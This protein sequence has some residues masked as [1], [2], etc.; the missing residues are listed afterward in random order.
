M[1]DYLDT[2]D[3][4]KS[5]PCYSVKNK[6]VLGKFKDEAN[7]AVIKAFVG[8]R[9]K[10]YSLRIDQ[11]EIRKANDGVKKAAL[12]SDIRFEDYLTCLRQKTS[13]RHPMNFIRST[14]HII[15]SMKI[16]K[17]SLSADDDKRIVL[18]DGISTLSL[19]HYKSNNL[20]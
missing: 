18:E 2:S 15:T 19:G 13:L 14:Q 4:P 20:L 8:L 16:N 12:K 11:H 10:M 1:M 17:K 3:Y 6:K 7:G 5:H 9:A